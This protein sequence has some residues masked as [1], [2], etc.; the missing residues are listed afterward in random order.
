MKPLLLIALSK[1]WSDEARAAAQA[2]RAANRAG[3]DPDEAAAAAK[4][5]V[6][7]GAS[8]EDA[9]KLGAE[10]SQVASSGWRAA[11]QDD[12]NHGDKISESVPNMSYGQAR[13]RYEGIEEALNQNPG[14]HLAPL[15][16]QASER[17]AE[18]LESQGD[19][20]HLKGSAKESYDYLRAKNGSFEA[21]D[22]GAFKRMYGLVPPG[23]GKP[24]PNTLREKRRTET[25][26]RFPSYQP[27]GRRK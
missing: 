11:P 2:A 26:A 18:A 23:M 4:Q 10:A 25:T 1:N 19:G 12:F 14:G 21:K 16:E 3:G 24:G 13:T 22:I 15:T 17:M 20:A 27:G 8:V 5:A 9:V 7:D 6:R